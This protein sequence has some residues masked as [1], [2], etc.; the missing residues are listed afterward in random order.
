MSKGGSGGP[1]MY[2]MIYMRFFSSTIWCLLL[3][4]TDMSLKQREYPVLAIRWI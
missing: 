3:A 2:L 1:Q 4:E